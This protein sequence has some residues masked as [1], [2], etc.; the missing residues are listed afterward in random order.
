MHPGR[1]HCFHPTRWCMCRYFAQRLLQ[2]SRGSPVRR[3][4]QAGLQ[5]TGC[6]NAQRKRRGRCAKRKKQQNEDNVAFQDIPR[7]S[8]RYNVAFQD[9]PRPSGRYKAR[10]AVRHTPVG[11]EALSHGYFNA[12]AQAGNLNRIVAPIL[13][14]VALARRFPSQ[15]KRRSSVAA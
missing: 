13:A 2:W 15:N 5:R 8:G 1:L 4:T 3:S 6:K 7:P 12:G 14:C 9:I 11:I 10:S